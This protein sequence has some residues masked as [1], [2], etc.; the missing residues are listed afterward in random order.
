MNIGVLVPAPM[1][2]EVLA[3]VEDL[4][5]RAGGLTGIVAVDPAL[6][7]IARLRTALRSLKRLAKT[8]IHAG[9]ATAAIGYAR[10]HGL[11]HALVPSA[12]LPETADVLA[13][14]RFDVVV[15]SSVGILR[16]VILDTPGV[17]FL[18]AHAGR[19]PRYGGM[20]VVEWQ[21]YNGDPVYGTVHRIDAGIDTGDILLEAPLDVGRP[22]TIAELRKLAFRRV[23]EMVPDALQGLE[24]GTLRFRRQ[25]EGVR[26]VQW[27]RMH[28]ELLRRVQRKLD[29]GSFF[30]AQEG[31]L[32]GRSPRE[33]AG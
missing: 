6:T 8:G 28:P 10:R 29:D 2:P 32:A 9:D 21:V 17:T 7:P 33:A 16:R 23:W 15:A 3:L 20:N 26:R 30:S 18:N 5:T 25:S 11:R 14:S 22:S 1:P 13:R 12:N 19:L 27:F 31:C 24:A 4:R